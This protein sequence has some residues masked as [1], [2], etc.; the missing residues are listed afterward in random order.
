MFASRHHFSRKE[1]EMFKPMLAVTTVVFCI[2]LTACGGSK[3]VAQANGTCGK[4]LTDLQTALNTG[5][6]TQDEYNRSREEALKNCYH[7]D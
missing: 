7:N 6:M 1:S 2:A 5:A 4:Q 3:A